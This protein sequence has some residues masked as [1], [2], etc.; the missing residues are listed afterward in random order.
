MAM[1]CLKSL[2]F[3][4]GVLLRISRLFGPDWHAKVEVEN[5]ETFLKLLWVACSRKLP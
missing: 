3:T 5:L 2:S 1:I 4:G